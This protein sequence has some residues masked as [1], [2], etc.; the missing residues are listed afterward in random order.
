MADRANARVQVYDVDGGFRRSFGTDFLTTPIGFVTHGDRR[1][2]RAPGRHRRE[3]EL[4]AYIGDNE[5][6]CDVEGWPNNKGDGGQIVPTSLLE[7]GKSKSPHGLAV[8]PNGNLSVAEWLI[9][10]RV[11]RLNRS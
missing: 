3:R 9:G 7:T 10:G 5:Q 11:T 4:L 1:A 2:S 6:V 8:D